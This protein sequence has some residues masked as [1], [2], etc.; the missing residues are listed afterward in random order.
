MAQVSGRV[1]YKDG[2]VPQGAVCNV[3]FL[4]AAG[5]SATKGRAAGGT[6]EPDGSFQMSTQQAGDG[7]LLGDYT[8]TFLV[9]RNPTDP[10]TSMVAPKY[11]IPGMTPYKITVE[12]DVS[13]LKYEIEP[14]PGG[15]TGAPPAAAAK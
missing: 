8:V 2:T 14:M 7:V 10:S 6:I 4:P 5:S 12:H 1:T 15:T 3:Q 13:D 9:W 11:G